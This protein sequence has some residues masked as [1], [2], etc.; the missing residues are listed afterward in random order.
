MPY[1]ES[2]VPSVTNQI[3]SIQTYFTIV[4]ILSFVF[5]LLIYFLFLKPSNE[6]KLSGFLKKLY[7]FLSFKTMTLEAIIKILY[8]FSTIFITIYSLS[9]I[10]QNFWL[11][12]LTLVIGNI[13]TRIVAEGSLLFLLIYKN[14]KDIRENIKT[15]K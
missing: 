7:D 15:K 5:A 11:F 4:L 13:T 6:D 3:Q 1:Y 9:L 14:T 2:S 12:L 10:G 8:L